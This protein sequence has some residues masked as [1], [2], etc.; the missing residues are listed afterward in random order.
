MALDLNPSFLKR[1]IAALPALHCVKAENFT[2]ANPA[3]P[4]LPVEGKRNILITSA[5]PYSNNLPHLGNVIGSVLSADVY[6]RYCK[7]RGYQ[8]LYICGTVSKRRLP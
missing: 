5:L 6:S 3:N 8:S 4:I 7:A 1:E 2:M